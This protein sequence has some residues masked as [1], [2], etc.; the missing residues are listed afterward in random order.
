[1]NFK[2]K[3]DIKPPPPPAPKGTIDP[4]AYAWQVT[5]RK[6]LPEVLQR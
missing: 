1:M 4:V 5:H 2:R 6:P 3:S